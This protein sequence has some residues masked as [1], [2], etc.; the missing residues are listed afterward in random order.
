[1]IISYYIEVL[2]PIPYVLPFAG[3]TLYHTI[4]GILLQILLYRIPYLV[5]AGYSEERQH[6]VAS[7]GCF[8]W[9]QPGAELLLRGGPR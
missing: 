9:L 3:Y 8:V 1:M 6:P 7:P 2:H 5:V 4:S